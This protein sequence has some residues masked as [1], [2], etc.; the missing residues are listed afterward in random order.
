MKTISYCLFAL[1]VAVGFRGQ[2][3][4]ADEILDN[5]FENIGGKENFKSLE[6]IKI[7][8]KV[9]QQGTEI[10]LE[11]YQ[12]ADGR[13]MTVV[14][15]QGQE[16]K[17]GVYDGE[18]LWSTNFQTMKP[19]KSDAE[20]TANFKLNTND[21]PD[22][23]LDYKAKGYTV[24]LV[25]T[26]TVEGTETFKVKLVKEPLTID[27]ETKEDISY[28][29]FDAE[30]FVPIALESEI[31]QGPMKGQTRYVTFSDY[32]EV[33]GLYFPFSITQGIK[34]QGSQ[35]ISMES[36]ELNPEVDPA[37]FDYPEEGSPEEE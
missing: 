12:M 23:F 16:I 9:N 27:G 14:K 24:E 3:Q 35:P 33:D 32:Q 19:Q 15:L 17:Q 22:S 30:N 8:A 7:N 6:G 11:I 29:F 31:H 10:P 25:G 1:L 21:F 28:Y 18:T 26:E 36:I 34:N 37:V 4:T 13:Q 2:A 20:T 5:Y